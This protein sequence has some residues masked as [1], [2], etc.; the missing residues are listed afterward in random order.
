MTQRM[1]WGLNN[2]KNQMSNLQQRVLTLE[3]DN[4]ILKKR[5]LFLEN[6]EALKGTVDEITM[7]DLNEL[8]K[9]R[10]EG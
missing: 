7:M 3:V 5:V 10:E 2:L 4:Q 6:I 8:D 1:N 9:I